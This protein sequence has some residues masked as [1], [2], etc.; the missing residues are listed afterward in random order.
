M[1]RYKRSVILSIFLVF[2]FIQLYSKDLSVVIDKLKTVSSLV[3]VY[4]VGEY[5]EQIP[6]VTGDIAE[7][8]PKTIVVLDSDQYLE[9][10]EIKINEIVYITIH[11]DPQESS[12][13]Y[14]KDEYKQKIIEYENIQKTPP[15]LIKA[16]KA[17]EE[18]LN[19]EI[20][21]YLFSE[22][23][24]FKS[25]IKILLERGNNTIFT[26]FDE[27][28]TVNILAEGTVKEISQDEF[29]VL[30]KST[31]QLVTIQNSDILDL[32]IYDLEVKR[33][34]YRVFVYPDLST[35]FSNIK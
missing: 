6:I 32:K 22:K 33:R 15:G 35:K 21:E 17:S 23:K 30:D 31:S 27:T 20:P 11:N 19:F 2:N 28:I 24:D 18:E 34:S 25:I 29:K 14:F 10:V 16:I 5:G 3:T 13:I 26:G 4:L 7:I 12:V 9:R 1:N 8:N